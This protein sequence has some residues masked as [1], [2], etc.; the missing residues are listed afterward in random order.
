[1]DNKDAK[2]AE[3][4]PLDKTKVNTL[5]LNCL[6]F[7]PCL[8]RKKSKEEKFFVKGL[9]MYRE[10]IDICE[11]F[12]TYMELKAVTKGVLSE[13]AAKKKAKGK[14]ANASREGALSRRNTVC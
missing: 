4:G 8:R 2:F 11:F 6:F 12:R 5:R 9:R 7:C 3:K 14:T 1:M 13:V 10:E